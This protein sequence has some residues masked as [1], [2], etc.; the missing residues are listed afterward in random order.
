MKTMTDM[1]FREPACEQAMD[2]LDSYMDGE[3]PA[4]SNIELLEHF[5]GCTSCTQ[6]AAA[7]RRIRSRLQT[8][9][10]SVQIPAD[11]ESR[12]R[13]NLRE[14]RRSHNWS[15]SVMAIAAGLAVCFGSW[16]AYH[17]GNLRMTAS[18]QESYV[19]EMSNRVAAIMRVAL[20]DHIHCAVFRRYPKNAVQTALPAEFSGL[21]PIVR[22]RV[23]KG[24]ALVL[25]HDCRYHG[26]RF[27]HFTF[28]NDSSL[29]SLVIARR[30]DGE[31][32]GAGNRILTDGV[33]R[34][35]I[36]GFESGGYLVYTVSDLPGNRNFE[37]MAALAPALQ[38]YLRQMKA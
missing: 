3:L 13:A 23:P 36:A 26:R 28:K 27:V 17:L 7:R 22:Q 16:L 15:Q 20:A 6:E 5:R 4:E 35:Q 24:L 21:L 30:Q 12:I 10:R 19:S 38:D 37:L 11:L 33:Q 9:V 18:S 29:L 8:A 34:F 31:A 14:G 32:F 2:R 1:R 25:A